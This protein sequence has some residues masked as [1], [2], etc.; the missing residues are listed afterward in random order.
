[1]KRNIRTLMATAVLIVSTA[2][3]ISCKNHSQDYGKVSED[4]AH[5]GEVNDRGSNDNLSPDGSPG[6]SPDT[7]DPYT[8][9][10]PTAPDMQNGTRNPSPTGTTTTPTDPPGTAGEGK[11]RP[12]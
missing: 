4:T 8:S 6:M 9:G 2:T 10:S 11:S 5:T 12:Q 1:M 7:I 3:F